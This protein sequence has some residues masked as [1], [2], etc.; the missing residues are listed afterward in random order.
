MAKTKTFL[1]YPQIAKA[2]TFLEQI[3]KESPIPTRPDALSRLRAE[4]DFEVSDGWFKGYVS[5]ANLPF[6]TI[7]I[8]REN[9]TEFER[10]I[11]GQIHACAKAIAQIHARRGEECPKDVL[12]I[13]T[14]RTLDD[15]DEKQQEDL[16]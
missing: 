12:G 14:C 11:C 1:T 8:A 4:M 13:L 15:C 10:R 6:R 3:A 5:A 2:G 16:L 9:R 7:R